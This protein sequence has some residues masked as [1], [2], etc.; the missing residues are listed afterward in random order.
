VT[1][2]YPDSIPE[3]PSNV[4]DV[5]RRASDRGPTVET[6]GNTRVLNP[7]DWQFSPGVLAERLAEVT[8]RKPL[9]AWERRG[10][11]EAEIKA[12]NDALEA[13][14]GPLPKQPISAAERDAMT[15]AQRQLWEDEW[16]EFNEAWKAYQD[17][18][19]ASKAKLSAPTEAEDNIAM[20]IEEIAKLRGKADARS[21]MMRENL[22]A[23]LAKWL[24]QK[25][26]SQAPTAPVSA[27]PPSA[28]P[29]APVTERVPVGTLGDETEFDGGIITWRA[30]IESLKGKTDAESNRKRAVAEKNI[31]EAL[32]H[33]IK[34]NHDAG[35]AQA[36]EEYAKLSPEELAQMIPDLKKMI[37]D[38]GYSADQKAVLQG[39]L[40]YIRSR[41]P[42]I[43]Q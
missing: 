37:E 1:G 6:G 4:A 2:A 25:Q 26:G 31:A 41:Q 10:M 22:Q 20:L 32:Q 42:Q 21:N 16:K 27:A 38:P 24:A 5:R 30:L 8:E 40:D 3:G 12:Y 33:K 14:G 7:W 34:A 11:T 19:R 9:T 29:P 13:L 39:V 43:I 35:F 15:Q 36:A 17:E 28:Q 23:Q 18:R